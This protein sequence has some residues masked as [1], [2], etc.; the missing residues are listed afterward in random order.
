[1]LLGGRNLCKRYSGSTPIAVNNVSDKLMQLIAN[2]IYKLPPKFAS[3]SIMS[4]TRGVGLSSPQASLTGHGA[5]AAA[6]WTWPD[7]GSR[8]LRLAASPYTAKPRRCA[9]SLLSACNMPEIC[10]TRGPV[11]PGHFEVIIYFLIVYCYMGRNV[12][13]Y[14]RR[15]RLTRELTAA[16]YFLGNRFLP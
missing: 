15:Y 6:A 5:A 12:L 8:G 9:H 3:W 7:A 4:S 16:N 14:L 1:M 11:T 10:L 13:E 2:M